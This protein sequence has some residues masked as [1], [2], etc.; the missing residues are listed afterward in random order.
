M[1]VQ[2]ALGNQLA[3]ATFGN[4][5][6]ADFF[7]DKILPTGNMTVYFRDG[8]LRDGFWNEAPLS[9]FLTTRAGPGAISETFGMV[10]PLL[11]LSSATKGTQG[12]GVTRQYGFTAYNNKTGTGADQTSIAFQDS[13]A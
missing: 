6:A 12:R 3:E 5:Q 2:I 1:Q 10:M 8:V 7:P 4:R 9:L 13:L 11:K